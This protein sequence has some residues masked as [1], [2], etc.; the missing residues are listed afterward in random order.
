MALQLNQV[1]I[2]LPVKDL[3]KS[4]AFYKEIGFEFN[5]Q[6]TNENAAC[7]VISEHI[8]AMLQTEEYFKGFTNKEIPDTR[9]QAQMILA[10][11]ATSREQV[12]DIV[13]RAM[14]AGA[15]K[16]NEPQDHG[17]MYSWSFQDLDGHLWEVL[18]MEP[19]NIEQ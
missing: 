8:F 13:N 6:F 3:D 10:F 9:S 1:F 11:S 19:A 7:L 5:A 14:A 2:N 12:D 18:Y 16:Y 17:F 15:S 4:M